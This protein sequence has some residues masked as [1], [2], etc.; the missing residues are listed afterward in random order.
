MHTSIRPVAPN[1]SSAY[2][3]YIS[4]YARYNFRP[5]H[6]NSVNFKQINNKKISIKKSQYN[7]KNRVFLPPD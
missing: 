7:P 3:Y 5:V 2:G 4:F 1:R 6:V